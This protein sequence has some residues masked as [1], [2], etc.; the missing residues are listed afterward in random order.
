MGRHK[1]V[2]LKNRFS[3]KPSLRSTLPTLCVLFVVL[4][5]MVRAQDPR[6]TSNVTNAAEITQQ[7]TSVVQ[8]LITHPAGTDQNQPPIL[9]TLQLPTATVGNLY[10]A[11]VTSWDYDTADTLNF[12]VVGLPG[13]LF[14]DCSSS[15]VKNIKKMD[16]VI[17][18]T[19]TYTFTTDSIFITVTDNRGGSISN[20]YNMDI[21]MPTPTVTPKI[22][23]SPT[24]NYE[25]P[26]WTPTP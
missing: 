2:T 18:G 5:F 19:P 11:T 20:R 25:Y 6:N 13:N 26:T 17:N 12:S 1:K 10:K 23:N 3:F 22:T 15:V 14:Y 8:P 7:P 16:C 9:T 21:L 24:S 4:T